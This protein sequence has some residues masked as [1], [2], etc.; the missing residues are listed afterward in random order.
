[1]MDDFLRQLGSVR[2]VFRFRND[3]F[4]IERY[5]SSHFMPPGRPRRWRQKCMDVLENL[6]QHRVEGNQLA[7]RASN[8]QWLALYLEVCRRII[9]ED[10]VVVRVSLFC[11]S[12]GLCC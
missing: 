6:V 2:Y 5:K 10:L 1:M 12:K 4:C 8:K 9:C 7:D 3:A 11:Y